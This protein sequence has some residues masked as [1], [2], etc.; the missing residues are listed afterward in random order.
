MRYRNIRT[1]NCKKDDCAS[2]KRKGMGTFVFNF[3][4]NIKTPIYLF[5]LRAKYYGNDTFP[6]P[7][8]IWQMY[9]RD[10]NRKH[11]TCNRSRHY[12]IQRRIPQQN[13]ST[14]ARHHCRRW[15]DM[16]AWQRDN[17]SGSVT[18]GHKTASTRRRG[19]FL[20]VYLHVIAWLMSIARC[21]Y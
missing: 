11:H 7:T 9:S 1:K 10:S 4:Y 8:H 15:L 3:F 19:F 14:R 13:I 21:V 17:G 12:P 18:P 20:R 6:F 16:A 5:L 2:H